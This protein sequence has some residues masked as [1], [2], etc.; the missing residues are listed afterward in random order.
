MAQV[1]KKQELDQYNTTAMKVELL[2]AAYMAGRRDF[3]RS[4][5]QNICLHKAHLA[6]INFSDA[7][8]NR[9]IL[10]KANLERAYFNRAILYAANLNQALMYQASLIEANLEK[11]TLSHATLNHTNLSGAN[12]RNA[13]LEHAQ[14]VWANLRGANLKDA[15]LDKANLTGAKF[16]QTIMPDGSIRNDQQFVVSK[17]ADYPQHPYLLIDLNQAIAPEL[18]DFYQQFKWLSFKLK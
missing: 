7:Y 16:G 6:A 11:A 1:I 17:G 8:L 10:S 12:L 18:L 3:S 2:K 9:A 13:N 4:Q 14:L 15:N 5:L